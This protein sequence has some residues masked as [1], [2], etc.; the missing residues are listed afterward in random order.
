MGTAGRRGSE[1]GSGSAGRQL[2][3]PLGR[4]AL[5]GGGRGRGS[6]GPRVSGACPAVSPLRAAPVHCGWVSG[7]EMTSFLGTG[8]LHR[9]V[10]VWPKMCSA[11]VRRISLWEACGFAVGPG[12]RP[13]PS[14]GYYASRSLI[15][16]LSFLTYGKVIVGIKARLWVNVRAWRVVSGDASPSFLPGT[17]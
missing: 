5:L 16:N 1:G 3:L 9:V 2:S 12:W 15:P 11:K 6:Q 10:T 4:E 8:S 17:I 7:V 13:G 14:R